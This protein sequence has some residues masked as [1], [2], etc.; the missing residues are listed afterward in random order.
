MIH[1]FATAPRTPREL[2]TRREPPTVPVVK[3]SRKLRGG[4]LFLVVV[5]AVW[6]ISTSAPVEVAEDLAP[7]VEAK[8]EYLQAATTEEVLLRG[9]ESEMKQTPA[10]TAPKPDPKLR[11]FERKAMASKQGGVENDYGFYDSLQASA[12][13]VPVQR[14]VY[15][16]AEDRKRASYTY[17]LQAASLKSRSEAVALVAKLQQ[18]GLAASY[19][20]SEGGFGEVSWYRVNVGPFNNVSIMNKAE[21]VL[22]SM[23]MMPLKRRVQ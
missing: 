16:T 22:V 5:L 21:D 4:L 19:S 14:G 18:R 3:K 23:H 11:E 12:W 10:D 20:E 8:A 9:P 13:R 15:L 7:I 6:R 17:I 1:D 2:P